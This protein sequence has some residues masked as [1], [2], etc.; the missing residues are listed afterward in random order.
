MDTP[1]SLD[2]LTALVKSHLKRMQYRTASLNGFVAQTGLTL[3][4]P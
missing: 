1:R 2:Q 4:P 3:E